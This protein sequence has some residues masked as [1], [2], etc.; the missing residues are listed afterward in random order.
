M[1]YFIPIIIAALFFSGCA[2]EAIYVDHEYGM[3]TMDAFD[4]QIVHKDYAYAN[5]PVDGMAGIHAET[6]MESYHDT[7]SDSFSKENIDV[8]ATGD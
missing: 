5:K 4:R 8:T 1:K 2:R 3:A 7:F 6:I